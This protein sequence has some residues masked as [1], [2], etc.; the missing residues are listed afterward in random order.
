[1]D[2][3]GLADPGIVPT[4]ALTGFAFL[5][6]KIAAW[7]ALGIVAVGFVTSCLCDILEYRKLRR[8]HG[9]SETWHMM[10]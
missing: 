1:M 9:R 5:I 7:G 8:C 4:D 3:L 6:I 2:L 10:P